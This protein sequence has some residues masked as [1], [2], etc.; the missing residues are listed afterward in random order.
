[1]AQNAR[2]SDY[3]H[4]GKAEITS[5]TL[6]QARYGEVHP[7]HAV[8]IYVTEDFS[9]S[10]Q[11]K[12]DRP[13]AAGA[14]RVPI[15]KLNFT[16]KFLTG[17]YPYSMMSSIFSPVDGS[18]GGQPLKVTTSSQEWCGHT[19][20]QLNRAGDGYR[21]RQLSYF[22]SEGDESVTLDDAMTEDGLWTTIRLDPSR[23]PTGALQLI[24]GTLYSRL[25]HLPWELQEATATLEPV[26]GQAG[27]M[28]YELHYPRLGRRL[29]IH[30]EKAF[31][32]AIEGWEEAYSSGWGPGAKTL[33]TR[34][35][36]LKSLLSDY[37][38]RHD[39]AD[40]NLR[41]ELGLE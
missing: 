3:W 22:E 17:I 29:T 36:R 16:K 21:I 1:M 14:D 13:G 4:Q 5:Y 9:R 34:A 26:T 41:Q 10:K 15:L 25:R 40:V 11:V 12:L 37:W 18:T 19:F 24:P 33:K 31:P 27:L 20:T 7:G 8:L 23:L 39:L 32:H 38:A 2:F 35:T 28:A 30:F 6:E